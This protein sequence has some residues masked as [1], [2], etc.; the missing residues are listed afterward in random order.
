MKSIKISTIDDSGKVVGEKAVSTPVLESPASPALVTQSILAFLANQRRALAKTKTRGEV[1][2]SGR[3]IWRQKGTGR[4][5]HGDR[6]API[7]VGGG[8]THGPRGDRNYTKKLNQKMAQK[9]VLSILVDRIKEK[10]VF[11]V[12]ELKLKKTKQAADFL[13]ELKKNL[14][15]EG[16]IAF[17]LSR[18]EETK[19]FLKNLKA[20]TLLDVDAFNSYFLLNTDFLFIT[21]KAWEKLQKRLEGKI[22][23]RKEV[24]EDESKH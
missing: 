20:V 2:G 5:R 22:K 7:F 13:R 21:E 24:K 12:G 3:K 23:T 16:K 15:A 9:A 4:A 18:E 8:V 6:Q 14:K 1:V 11:L 10:K 17:L 19:R